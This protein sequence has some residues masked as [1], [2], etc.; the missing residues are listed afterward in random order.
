VLQERTERIELE[1]AKTLKAFILSGVLLSFPPA[2]FAADFDPGYLC[3]VLLSKIPFLGKPANNALDADLSRITLKID[4]D[5]SRSIVKAG[6][7]DPVLWEESK[8]R[9]RPV[10]EYIGFDA[11]AFESPVES[12]L[13]PPIGGRNLKGIPHSQTAGDFLVAV[14]DLSP[15][16]VRRVNRMGL[17]SSDLFLLWDQVVDR[18]KGE[19]DKLLS[20]KTKDFVRIILETPPALDF[21]TTAG[22]VSNL[23]RMVELER[24]GH[25]PAQ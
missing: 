17:N 13:P 21:I 4:L 16:A 5:A 23:K 7:Q 2:I 14:M 22:M 9:M 18:K 24:A 12:L 15:L 1:M 10:A 11:E 6:K 19:L 25:T 3:D 20:R 8:E